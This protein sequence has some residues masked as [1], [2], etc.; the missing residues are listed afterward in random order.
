MSCCPAGSLPALKTEYE[1][2][3]KVVNKGGLDIYEVGGDSTQAI[4][5]IY[6]IFGFEG[7]SRIRAICDQLAAETGFAVFLPDYYHGE[8]WGAD[9]PLDESLYAWVKTMPIEGVQSD[10]K[11]VLARLTERGVTAYGTIGFCWGCWAQFNFA[12]CAEDKLLKCSVHCHPSLV[13]EG[14]FGRN[15][16]DLAK[17]VLHPQLFLPASNDKDN[18][19]E[20]GEVIAALKDVQVHHYAD[21]VHGFVTRG[22][23]KDEKVSRDVKDALER[24]A[25]YFKSHL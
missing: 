7:I 20:G 24:A 1:C 25:G 6:D 14:L 5:V 18:V 9:A 4:V 22:D 8:K 11:K 2:V 15:E 16:V 10:H 3:G 23:L 17:K 19:K 13:I 21:M 12:S